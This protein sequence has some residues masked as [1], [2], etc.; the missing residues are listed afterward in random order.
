MSETWTLI[1]ILN[2]TM[3]AFK[4]R[5]LPNARLEAEVLLAHVLGMERIGLYTSFDRPLLEGERNAFRDLVKR[6]FAGEP[7]QYL[8]GKQEFWSM[9]FEVS[10]AVLVPRPD[11][12]V[13]VEEALEYLIARKRQ[14]R[15]LDVGTGSGAI[16][17]SLAKECPEV[18]MTA[19]DVSLPAL[20]VARRNAVTHG[21]DVS[22]VHGPVTALPPDFQVD[23]LVSNPP[24]IP[25]ETLD[26]LMIE[27]RKH[28]PSLALDGGADGL[29]VFR[30]ILNRAPDLVVSGGWIGFEVE[31]PRQADEVFLILEQ[32][33]AWSDAKIRRDYS[34]IPRVVSALR[35]DS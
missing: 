6:R 25:T 27:V 30:E 19:C 17:L 31:G 32:S 22:F 26:T 28:E 16:A 12:E 33:E 13:L 23:V 5:D 14:G 1:K 10:S 7:S 34:G 8:V 18:E 20:D 15:V 21:L 29:H 11:T 2:W 3:D 4:K 9:D 35:S 24:Y